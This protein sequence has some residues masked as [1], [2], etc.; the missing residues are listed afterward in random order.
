M[1]RLEKIFGNKRI[2]ALCGNKNTGKTNNLVDLIREQRRKTPDLNI[3]IFGFEPIVTKY[4]INALKCVEI[5]DMRHLNGKRNTLF[6]LDEFQ[7]LNLNDR[8]YKEQRDLIVDFIYHDNNLLLLSSPNIREFNTV[9][10]GIIEKWL[11][12]SVSLN[13]CINGSQLKEIVKNYKGRYKSLNDIRTEVN[14]LL[15]INDEYEE[16]ILCE[17]VPE[18]DS[19]TN[20]K[21]ILSK[22]LTSSESSELSE[23][24]CY[25]EFMEDWREQ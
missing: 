1:T 23:K 9:I 11:L 6:I 18:A 15:L 10:G 4:L 13:Q 25:E 5:S 22:E 2:I 19:K 16:V 21:S 17:Y 12:K 24:D 3:C 7:R 14:E 20:N 8:R